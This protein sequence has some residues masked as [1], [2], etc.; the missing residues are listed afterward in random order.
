[1]SLQADRDRPGR[2]SDGEPRTDGPPA[3]GRW[4]A[5]TLAAALGLA[6]AFGAAWYV[7]GAYRGA[8]ADGGGAEGEADPAGAAVGADSAR[9][10][11]GALATRGTPG[12][13]RWLSIRAPV[14]TFPTLEGDTSSLAAHRGEVVVLNFW[15]TWCPPCEREIPELAQLQDSLGSEGATVVGLAVSSGSREDIRSFGD[16]HG[17]D[18]PVWLT[19]PGTAATEY[20]AMGLPLTLLVDR[21]GVIRRRYMGPQTYETMSDDVRALL[22]STRA[23]PGEGSGAEAGEATTG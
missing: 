2:G 14:V 4:V 3:G 6:V 19:D 17:I 11:G 15:A 7:A 22:D 16:E 20:D 1:M 9:S 18:Y 5:R 13:S 10:A 12:R 21:E 8:G 23:P